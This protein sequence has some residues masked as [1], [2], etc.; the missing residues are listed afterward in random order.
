MKNQELK[1]TFLIF[2]ICLGILFFFY[3]EVLLNLNAYI[4]SNQ[5]DGI[6]NYYTYLYHA[7]YDKEFW[8]FYGM[9]YPYYENI[10]YTD[11]HPLL[12]YLIG[13]LGL[14]NYGVGILNFFM[15]IS[16]PIAGVFIFKIFRH[17]KV[18]VLIAILSTI[19]ITFMAPQAFRITG[20]FSLSYVFAI[21]CLWYFLIKVNESKKMIWSLIISVYIL[22]FFFTHPYLGL[23]LAVFALFYAL[24]KWIFHWRDKKQFW[25]LIKSIF[26]QI[27]VPIIIFQGLVF[28]FDTHEDRMKSP[29]GFF[30]FYAT[31]KSIVIP[32]HG[33]LL[34]VKGWL[35]GNSGEWESWNYV[36]FGAILFFIFI[37]IDF[38]KERKNIYT[39]KSIISHPIFLFYIA[40]HLVLLFSFCFP[41]KFEWFRGVVEIFGPLKQF[42]VLG[43]FAWIY[44]Y[45]FTIG[46]FVLFYEL[47]KRK[48]KK[49][50]NYVFYLGILFYFFEFYPV[51][52]NLAKAVSMT[53]NPFLVENVSP[54]M[55]EIVDLTNQNNY[56]AIIFLPFEHLSSE[57]VYILGRENSGFDA[58]VLSYHTNT[59]LLN[60]ISSRTSVTESI[61]YQNLFSPE[62]IEKELLHIIGY[63]RKILLVKNNDGLNSSEQRMTWCSEKIYQNENYTAYNFDFNRWNDP[64]Y[65][66]RIIDLSQNVNIQVS[67]GW[68]SDT[69]NVWYYYNSF[70][71]RKE[72]TTLLGNGAFAD[73]KVQFNIIEKFD[74]N[75]FEEGEYTLS[76]WYHIRTDRPDVLAVVELNFENDSSAWVDQKDI[77]ETN[78]IVEDW[79]YTE[80]H[81][82]INKKVKEV[83]FFLT[84]NNSKQWFVIDELLILKKN[85]SPLFKKA[86]KN[87]K[88]YLIYNNFWLLEDSY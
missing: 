61:H 49:Y 80:L 13:K 23:I 9:N 65:F 27:L 81:F 22:I 75:Q 51:H 2:F 40:A 15:L 45:V 88:K 31:W 79:A 18:E 60:T 73:K 53:P 83:T 1:Y 14:A 33:P 58:M 8:N 16:Y 69:S 55:K 77:R 30:D 68:Y 67:D 63:D 50:L 71:D 84:G 62:F 5:G 19:V 46:V 56:D 70:E 38:F 78:L 42:R 37:G 12:S 26:V 34:T 25:N 74:A 3:H 21:P 44:F 28:F 54:E 10:V 43:R 87:G 72:K 64:Q 4:F 47:K 48:S 20:H 7:K 41:F 6:K 35:N 24:V 52:K 29:S 32:H 39:K 59:P 76:F 86:E 57:N 66:N 82:T 85:Q 36:G 17:F 11:A